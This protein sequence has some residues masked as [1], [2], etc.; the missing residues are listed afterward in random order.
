MKT[1][2]ESIQKLLQTEDLQLKEL[3]QIVVDTLREEKLISRRLRRE[4]DKKPNFAELIADKVA[5]FGGS[6]KFIIAFALI[7]TLWIFINSYYVTTHAFDPYPFILL[8]LILSCVAALQAPVILM[9]QNRLEAKDRKRSE[10][11]YLINLKAELEIRGLHQK[12]D[13]LIMEQMTT[14]L[15]TQKQQLEYLSEMRKKDQGLF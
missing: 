8:N 12:I 13:M 14:L 4:F 6:W 3:H 5:T 10:H 11:D 9:S 2:A 7:V 15:E 1:P